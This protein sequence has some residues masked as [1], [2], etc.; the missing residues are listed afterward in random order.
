MAVKKTETFFLDHLGWTCAIAILMIVLSYFFLDIHL[1]LLFHDI[2]PTESILLHLFNEL[3]NP[4]PQ[5]LFWPVIFFVVRYVYNNRSAGEKILTIALS[6]CVS[7]AISIPMKMLLGRARPAL[8][9]SE[10]V[11][12]FDIF[13]AYTLHL[14]FPSGHAITIASVMGALA[15]YYPRY[16]MPLL[17]LALF[18]GFARVMATAHYLSD[19]L[20]GVLLGILI[21]QW[22]FSRIKKCS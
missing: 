12:S 22:V 1:A 20:A 18:M 16:S 11:Y 19:V 8:L 6:V 10:H 13:S 7:N 15:C 2:W 3:S 9:F 17:F 14:S 21:S 5:V 4:N